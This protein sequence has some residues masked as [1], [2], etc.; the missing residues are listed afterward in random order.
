M[1]TKGNFCQISKIIS[2]IK[3]SS[4]K[5]HYKIEQMSKHVQQK[6]E[7]FYQ[8]NINPVVSKQDYCYI[9]I[10]DRYIN[11]SRNLFNKT[12]THV[13]CPPVKTDFVSFTQLFT[14]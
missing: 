1:L 14:L 8:N 2:K 4:I 5:Y 10:D 6:V 7:T 12:L 11:S 9:G 13:F 3:K